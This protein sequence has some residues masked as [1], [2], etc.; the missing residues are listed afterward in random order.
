[1]GPAEHPSLEG[2]LPTGTWNKAAGRRHLVKHR[3]DTEG[4]PEAEVEDT[5]SGQRTAEQR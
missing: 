5:V 3:G 4:I 1:M 2:T